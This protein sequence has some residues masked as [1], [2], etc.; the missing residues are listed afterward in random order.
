[1][2]LALPYALRV[3]R[4]KADSVPERGDQILY[5]A[6]K[7]LYIVVVIKNIICQPA[8]F[9]FV[10]LRLYAGANLGFSASIARAAA[11]APH[12]APHWQ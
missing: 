5:L 10:H 1:M 4:R 6:L 7:I 3:V 11:R 2:S 9:R 8:F 12:V